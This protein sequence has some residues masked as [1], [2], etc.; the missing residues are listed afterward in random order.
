[1][2]GGAITFYL[3]AGAQAGMVKCAS[4]FGW[5]RHELSISG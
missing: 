4:I 3:V 1:M 5:P 2:A